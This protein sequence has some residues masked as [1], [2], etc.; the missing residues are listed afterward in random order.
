MLGINSSGTVFDKAVVDKL[1]PRKDSPSKCVI[2]ITW[3]R[4]ELKPNAFTESS[5]L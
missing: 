5:S 3:L 1:D 2:T 4:P